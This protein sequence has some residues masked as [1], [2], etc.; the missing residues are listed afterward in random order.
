MTIDA[1]PGGQD[2]SVTTTVI[3]PAAAGD[4][5]AILALADT[6]RQQYAGYQPRFWR[7][8]P[9]ATARQAPYLAALIA[10]PAVITLV[11]VTGADLV[12]YAVGQLAPAPPVY[13][14]GG[15][16]CLVDDFTVAESGLW[17]TVGLDLLAAVT[18]TATAR[19][20]AQVVVVTADG[21]QVNLPRAAH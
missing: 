4:L 20:A 10:D 1:L 2:Q 11:A 21:A 9:D 5:D 7:P 19:G 14:P 18:R 6:R 16:T 15:P 12:G 3:R 13:D 17:T 8:A